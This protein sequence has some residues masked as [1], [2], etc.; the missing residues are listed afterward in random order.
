MP[1]KHGSF[2]HGWY[3]H[4]MRDNI[5]VFIM[6]HIYMKCLINMELNDGWYLHKMPDKH[7]SFYDGWYLHE[8]PDKHGSFHM[9]DCIYLKGLI[10]MEFL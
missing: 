9:I 8:M 5:G 3:L 10:N 4:E 6:D 7:G 2:Y 1:D